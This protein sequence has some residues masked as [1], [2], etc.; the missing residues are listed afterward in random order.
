[1]CES[2]SSFSFKKKKLIPKWKSEIGKVKQTG[3]SKQLTEEQN[4]THSKHAN[5]TRKYYYWQQVIWKNN[6]P[7]MPNKS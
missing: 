4:R 6:Q 7:K 3:R 2:N 5:V 1:M